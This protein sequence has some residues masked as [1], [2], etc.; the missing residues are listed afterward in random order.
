MNKSRLDGTTDEQTDA[1][2]CTI[3][4][5]MKRETVTVPLKGIGDF[6]SKMKRSELVYT[7]DTQ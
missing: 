7:G 4:E 5:Q 2:Y 3:F 6:W 1:V